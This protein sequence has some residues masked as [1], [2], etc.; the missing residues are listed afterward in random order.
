[1]SNA[2][3]LS[4][5]VVDAFI[6]CLYELFASLIWIEQVLL[7]GGLFAADRDCIA[8]EVNRNR[9]IGEI[10]ANVD[11][12]FFKAHLSQM[13]WQKAPVGTP[14]LSSSLNLMP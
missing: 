13:T 12:R 9:N 10:G 4:I 5:Q 11:K 1:M 3:Q 7:Q 2:R 14:S 8:P 6:G